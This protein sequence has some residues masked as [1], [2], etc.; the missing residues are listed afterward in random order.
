MNKSDK[1]SI[2]LDDIPHRHLLLH[3]HP[4][5]ER[6][7][8]LRLVLSLFLLLL[9]L[10]ALAL[11]VSYLLQAPMRAYAPLTPWLDLVCKV[12][13]CRAADTPFDDLRIVSREVISHPS[14]QRAVLVNA[15]LINQGSSAVAFPLLELGFKNFNGD[16][17]ARRRFQPNEYLADELDIAAGIPPKQLIRL[18]LELLDPGEAAVAF[19]F[20]FVAAP[21]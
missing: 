16:T 8:G 7:S 10:A 21:G 20:G 19:E 18:S 5:G 9:L 12:L 11:Q 13:P 6:R 14:S 1:I 3:Q 17:V 4:Q 15:T 2:R